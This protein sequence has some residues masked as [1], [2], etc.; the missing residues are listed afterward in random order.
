MTID[1]VLIPPVSHYLGGMVGVAKATHS[2]IQYKGQVSEEMTAAI[3]RARLAFL[4]QCEGLLN[5]PNKYVKQSGYQLSPQDLEF[6]QKVLDTARQIDW[7]NPQKVKDLGD[8]V[9]SQCR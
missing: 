3:E 4:Q 1:N 6:L 2:E 9:D 8:F 5:N 7:N